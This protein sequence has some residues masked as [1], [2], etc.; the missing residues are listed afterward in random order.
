MELGVALLFD[1][2][3]HLSWEASFAESRLLTFYFQS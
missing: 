1:A 2:L 3:P